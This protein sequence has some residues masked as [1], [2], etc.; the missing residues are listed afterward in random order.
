MI[1]TIIAAAVAIGSC[2]T[3]FNI[4]KARMTATYGPTNIHS[5]LLP[6]NA[7]VTVFKLNSKG[8]VVDQFVIISAKT[9]EVNS[10]S[11]NHTT[12]LVG[13]CRLDGDTEI[14]NMYHI[15]PKATSKK[16]EKI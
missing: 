6:N 7:G 1:G 13:Q 16:S 8:E 5:V 4:E 2:Q 15:L 9:K 11:P 12:Q 14:N 3:A 10:S